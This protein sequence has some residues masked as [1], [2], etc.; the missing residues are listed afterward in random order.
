MV[1]LSACN[2]AAG[3]RADAQAL[4]GLARSFFYAG[5]RS[6][7]VTHWSVNDQIAAY[8]VADSLRR[9][10]D[11]P[12]AFKQYRELVAAL[13]PDR[14]SNPYYAAEDERPKLARLYEQACFQQAYCLSQIDGA[15][16]QVDRPAGFFRG[17]G[18]GE[19]HLA[20]RRVADEADRIEE[21]ARRTGGDEAAEGQG[22]KA[23]SGWRL[24][25]GG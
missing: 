16:D 1:L 6:L 13:D 17:R 9:L 22:A 20:R 24:A 8:L 11:Y 7:L 5:A 10:E 2:T 12:E 25:V 3:A 4:S 18:Q 15:G 23:V 19:A 21:L 14:A